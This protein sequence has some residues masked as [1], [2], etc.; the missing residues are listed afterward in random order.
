M[1]SFRSAVAALLLV[2]ATAASAASDRVDLPV[3]GGSSLGFF[4][5][6]GEAVVEMIRREY[7]G[8]AVSYEPGNQAGAFAAMV[9]GRDA[10]VMAPAMVLSFA[11]DGAAPFTRRYDA[12]EFCVLARI[13]EGQSTLVMARADFAREHRLASL[14]DLARNRAPVRLSTNPPGNLYARSVVNDG[15]FALSGINDDAVRSWGGQSY[16]IG[17]RASTDM[18]IDRKL[19]LYINASW[20]PSADVLRVARSLAVVALPVEHELVNQVAARLDLDTGWIRAGT[21]PF[22]TDDYYTVEVPSYLVAAARLPQATAYRIAR[23]LHRHFDSY[24]ATNPGFAAF[25][26]GMLA[27]IPAGRFCVHPGAARY[28]REAGLL[29]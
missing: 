11:I 9:A 15:L 8:S 25:S 16:P 23:A 18:F 19:D 13:A 5:Q 1:W 10:L 4:Q 27:R 17:A 3:T 29:R 6:L 20:P 12:Q 28:Y 24:R 26:D 2:A 7:P 22:L 14:G 21:Y